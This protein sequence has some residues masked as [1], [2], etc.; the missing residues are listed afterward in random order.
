MQMQQED[1][2][3]LEEL[4]E[5]IEQSRVSRRVVPGYGRPVVSRGSCITLT[6]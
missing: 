6:S 5:V 3:M 2:Y 4:R 1:I